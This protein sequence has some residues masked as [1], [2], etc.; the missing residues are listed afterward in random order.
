[1][2]MADLANDIAQIE[3]QS[4][5]SP[6]PERQTSAGS[7]GSS[8]HP[9]ASSSTSF[10]SDSPYY[11]AFTSAE[12]QS[13]AVMGETLQDISEKARTLT[14]TGSFMGEACRRM[15][16]CCALRGGLP[17]EPIEGKTIEEMK[18]L[19]EDIYQ[20]RKMAVGD[21]MASLLSVVA[22]LVSEVADAQMNLCRTLDSTLGDTFEAFVNSE[23]QTVKILNQEATSATENAESQYAKYVTAKTPNLDASSLKEKEGGFLARGASWAGRVRSKAGAGGG[24]ANG[25]EDA[26]SRAT[27]AADLRLQLENIRFTQA[28][29]ENKRF[30]LM[31]H[32]I[33]LKH[34]RNF[35]LGE[36]T[37]AFVHGMRAYH[38]HCADVVAG[39]VPRLSRIQ[40]HQ[41]T[42]STNFADS[43]VPK[44][45]ERQVNLEQ[46]VGRVQKEANDA[47]GIAQA[48]AAGDPQLIDRQITNV[49]EIEKRVH[50]WD[51]PNE[52]SETS[53]FQ[54]EK[55]P[56]I[57]IEG[58]L[59][60]KSSA[61]ISLQPWQRRWFVM[62]NQSIYY[63]HDG[64][65]KKSSNNNN[66][67]NGALSADG[68]YDNDV[69]SAHRVKI[70]DVV[71][72]TIRELRPADAN[73]RR[74]CF[75]LVT[76]S[77]RPLTLQA[78]GPAEYRLWI[79]KIR[80][81]A[82]AQLVHGN[83]AEDL[84]KNI[85]VKAA[86]RT[87]LG[88]CSVSDDEYSDEGEMDL[89]TGLAEDA[90]PAV[91]GKFVSLI[92]SANPKCADCGAP[93]PD[94]ASLNLGVVICVECSGV[95]RSLGVHVSKVRSLMLD[96]LSESDYR[97]LLAL[98]NNVVNPIW[99]GNVAQQKGWSKPQED[100]ERKERDEW[101]RS[102]YQWKGFLKVEESDG[103]T[104]EERVQKY[105]NDLLHA[106]KRADIVAMARALS[107]G[108]NV[109]H[110]YPDD[111]GRTALHVCALAKRPDDVNVES[112]YGKECLELLIQNGA[113]MDAL[114]GSHHNVLDC[115][116]LAGASVETVGYLTKKVG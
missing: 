52:L 55:L 81:N 63:Y 104:E 77:E 107:H 97:L 38:H 67:S 111:G 14:R 36:S 101:I 59:Y 115:A 5:L 29:S 96:T 112:W 94:W 84:N 87:S 58:W 78:R 95:H 51:L 46:F 86:R 106:A 71:L 13:L 89:A 32:L 99:E 61:M 50:L 60:K 19:E 21:D 85:G 110:K 69:H 80:T 2:T 43:V 103:S 24:G 27:L 82:E 100:A 34:R 31:K 25:A 15:A 33:D 35:E 28:D 9:K 109:D 72:T 73:D 83:H 108:A 44:W 79:D 54:R 3:A 90:S 65:E 47:A 113:K 62:D 42:L 92:M 88:G 64:S 56:G 116:L 91:K 10:I 4:G 1:M 70:C 68:T 8:K 16:Q 39:T 75:Q 57:L 49:D 22:N 53:F 17:L 40:E 37:M 6:P 26:L 114:D 66:D 76:P 98:G 12:M 74:F 23:L 18:Q 93:N 105:T 7:D 20:H 30:Q 48:V 41:V 45:Q 11:D 102:K